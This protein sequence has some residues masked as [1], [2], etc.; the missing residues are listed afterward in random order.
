MDANR[1]RSD[2]YFHLISVSLSGVQYCQ[3]TLH[4]LFKPVTSIFFWGATETKVELCFL[5]LK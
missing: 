4:F 2:D 3:I 1:V 5:S